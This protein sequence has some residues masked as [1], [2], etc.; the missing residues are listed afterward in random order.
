MA[1]LHKL[2]QIDQSCQHFVHHLALLFNLGRF[3]P[4]LAPSTKNTFVDQEL[5][6]NGTELD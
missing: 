1:T 6:D 2:L 4:A 3:W 5:F